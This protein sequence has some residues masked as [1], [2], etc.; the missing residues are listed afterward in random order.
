[1]SFIA[2]KG[3]QG[4]VLP[5]SD[6]AMPGWCPARTV[7]RGDGKNKWKTLV[8]TTASPVSEL[9]RFVLGAASSPTSATSSAG[10][11][12]TPTCLDW[13]HA[14]RADILR[15]GVWASVA[16]AGV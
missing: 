10:P 14:E 5:S 8:S 6:C 15:L 13:T 3:Q 1:M 2:G 4:S 12:A 7:S 16:Q 9:C 11:K